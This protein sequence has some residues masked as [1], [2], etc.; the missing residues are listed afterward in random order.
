[1]PQ[2]DAFVLLEPGLREFSRMM[3]ADPKGNR[4]EQA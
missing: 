2:A 3:T 4:G 1:M